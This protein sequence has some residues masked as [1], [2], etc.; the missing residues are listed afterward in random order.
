MTAGKTESGAFVAPGQPGSV[1]DVKPRYEN[2]IG[3]RWVAPVKGQYMK[4]ISPVTG[5]PFTDVAKSTPEDVEL[6][7]DAA[8]AAK[9]AGARPRWPSVPPCST[10]S[11][12]PSRPT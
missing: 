10:P 2:F 7:L 5:R 4:N 8:H 9:D 1:V 6:A 11:P 3:G 12:M